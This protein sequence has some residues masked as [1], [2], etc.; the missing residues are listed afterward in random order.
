MVNFLKHIKSFVAVLVISTLSVGQLIAVDKD[1]GEKVSD[2]TVVKSEPGNEL[3]KTDKQKELNADSLQSADKIG[4]NSKK[5]V[6]N[7]SKVKKSNNSSPSIFSYN[8][9]FY[10]MYKFK[11]ADILD[12]S[13]EKN[14]AAI[15]PNESTF[16]LSG[17]R[18]VNKL[19]YSITH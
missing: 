13:K 5:G 4:Q 3:N 18:L 8:F 1:A 6:E 7:Q 14:S 2:K 19:I 12:I 15:L 16:L 10:L 9:V 11:I 17:K